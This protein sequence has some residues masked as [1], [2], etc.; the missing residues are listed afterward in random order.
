M[1]TLIK[2]LYV[3]STGTHQYLDS[4][5][6]HTCHWKKSI[7]YSQALRLNRICSVNAFFDQKFNKLEHWL[8][9]QGD[10]ERVVSQEILKARNEL[11]EKERNTK[12]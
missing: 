10:I 12:K 1:E 9:E 4:S 3:R 6:F 2:D 11:L 7:P 5:S 8:D